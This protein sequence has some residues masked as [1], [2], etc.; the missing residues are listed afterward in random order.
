MVSVGKER[1]TTTRVAARAG[2]SVG[3]LYQGFPKKSSLLQAALKRHR[4]EMVEAIEAECAAESGKPLRHMATARM[5]AFL[6]EKMRNTKTSVALYS[7]S[8]EAGSGRFLCLSTSMPRKCENLICMS[9]TAILDLPV[10]RIN[11]FST[12]LAEHKGKVVLVVNV[13]S[14][15]G[16]TPQYSGLERLYRT[17]RDH[18]FVVCGFPAND[19]AGQEPGSNEEIKG[20][21]TTTFGVDFPMYEKVEVTGGARHPLY[22][23]LIEAAPQTTG[24][25]TG[26][27]QHLVE[28]GVTPT[29]APEILW[30]FEKFLL[31]RDGRVAARFAPDLEP[32]DPAIRTAIE[33]ALGNA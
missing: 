29:R 26:F 31:G 27:R 18:G 33:T 6:A 28:F 14:K 8:S 24:D 16:L 25:T 3:T 5:T 11:G 13:A 22:T 10:R 2:V 9:S 21:C 12:T 30:N 23:A 20:F 15:C 1:L 32:E 17:Y 19:F 7:V 4:C